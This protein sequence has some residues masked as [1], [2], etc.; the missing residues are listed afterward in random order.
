MGD[1]K[2][3]ELPYFNLGLFTGILKMGYIHEMY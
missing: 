1:H 2:Y 3:K